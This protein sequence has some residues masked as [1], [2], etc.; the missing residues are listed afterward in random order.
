MTQESFAIALWHFVCFSDTAV[1]KTNPSSPV[2]GR[3]YG[4]L[5]TDSERESFLVKLLSAKG[6]VVLC[7]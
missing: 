4:P 6:V 3:T 7:A 5:V 2:R 1:E